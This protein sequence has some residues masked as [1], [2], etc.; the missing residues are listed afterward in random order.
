MIINFS[1]HPSDKWGDDQT[2]VAVSDFGH[3]LDLKFPTVD[4]AV[5]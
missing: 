5:A 4:E 3:I 2:R 1:N